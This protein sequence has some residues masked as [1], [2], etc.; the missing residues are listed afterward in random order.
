MAYTA[1]FGNGFSATIAAEAP[2]KT[3][4]AIVGDFLT[5]GFVA[6]GTGFGAGGAQAG[7]GGFQAPDIVANLRVD[8]AWGSAQLS[9]ALHQRQYVVLRN[10]LPTRQQAMLDDKL[11]WALLPV[12]S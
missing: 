2:R 7:Y 6:G 5:P 8:Q 1:Q 3:Q 10:T 4:I 9:G 12:S 11:G